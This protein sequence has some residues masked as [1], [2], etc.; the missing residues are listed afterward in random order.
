[1]LKPSQDAYGQLVYEFHQG[2]YSDEVVERDDGFIDTSAGPTYYF[3]AFEQ[4]P[5][6]EQRAMD[7]VRGR[8]LDIGAG[9]GRC[10]LYLQGRG[11]H[12]L[13]TDISPLA[14]KTCKLRGV[15]HAGVVPITELSRRLGVFDTILMM[16]NNFGLFGN[17]R[18]ARWLL[19]RFLGMTSPGARIVAETTDPHKTDNPDH[20]AYHRRN[21]RRGRLPGQLRLR[22]RHRRFCTPWFDYLFVSPAEMARILSGTGWRLAECIV[23]DGPTYVA[24]IEREDGPEG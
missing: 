24:V 5:P 3:A 8:V 6:H 1:V 19:R 18:R 11:H 23:S 12:V 14:I 22:V 15:R 2:K 4:W 7:Y 9:A 16:G 10:C 13:A 21:R 17:A 20:V